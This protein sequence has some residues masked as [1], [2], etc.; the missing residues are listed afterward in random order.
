MTSLTFGLF[1]KMS[2]SGTLVSFFSGPLITTSCSMNL[3]WSTFSFILPVLFGGGLSVCRFAVCSYICLSAVSP[4]VRLSVCPG[5]YQRWAVLVR[6]VGK[7]SFGEWMLTSVCRSR[8]ILRNWHNLISCPTKTVCGKRQYK[9]SHHQ[10][11]H[12]KQPCEQSFPM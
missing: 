12:Q 7:Q 10:R 3:G 9:I 8:K 5:S 4:Y 6:I 11:R 1:T 2:D